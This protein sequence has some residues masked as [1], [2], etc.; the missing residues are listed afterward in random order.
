MWEVFSGKSVFWSPS[1]E[2]I[3]GFLI[4]ICSQGGLT[5]L[6]VSEMRVILEFGGN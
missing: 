6:V 4:S 3:F 2:Y 5:G 1:D